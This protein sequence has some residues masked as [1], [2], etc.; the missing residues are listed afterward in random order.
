MSASAL[1]QLGP[2]SLVS[3]TVDRSADEIASVCLDEENIG[4]LALRHLLSTGLTQVSTCRYNASPFAVAR[5]RAFVE[6]ARAAGIKVAVGWG[7]DEAVPLKWAEDPAVPR[8]MPTESLRPSAMVAWLQA[9][10]KPCGI[11]TCTDGWARP[12]VRCTRVAGLRVPE[13]IALVGADNDAL[14]CELMAPPLSSVIIPWQEVGKSAAKLVQ[15][16]LSGEAI[17]GKRLVISPLA[18]LAR[19]SSDVLAIDDALVASAVRWIRANIDRRLTVTMVARAVGSGRQ[20]LERRFRGVLDRTVNDEIRRAHVEAAREL[21]GTTVVGL[22]E[23]A[24]R[25]GFTNA[26]L[27]NVAFQREIGMP[28]GAY[29]RRVRQE[30][31][32]ASRD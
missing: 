29:R 31:S 1:G 23:I 8:V 32:G 19:R 26:A 15:Q 22:A 7:S 14:E 30:L 2:A 28:P 11:F 21:L 5:E 24:K 9:L 27:L 18:V 13:D 16:A 6:G 17:A 20:R 4:A 3:V 25:S 12:V 10:P